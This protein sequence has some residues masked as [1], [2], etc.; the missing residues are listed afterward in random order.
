M[1]QEWTIPRENKTQVRGVTAVK[2]PSL[3][4][5]VGSVHAG[6]ADISGRWV[7]CYRQNFYLLIS[8]ERAARSS[9]QLAPRSPRARLSLTSLLRAHGVA[10][11]VLEPTRT[12]HSTSSPWERRDE[13]DGLGLAAP[14][15]ADTG[16]MP[17]GLPLPL[18]SWRSN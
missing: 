4:A 10:S 5:A 12:H 2:A 17:S 8:L 1:T 15:P 6:Q 9:H 16:L 14:G 3:W 13:G 7:I 18:T 11:L